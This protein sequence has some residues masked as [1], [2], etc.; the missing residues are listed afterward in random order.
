VRAILDPN[1]LI[2]A[3]LSRR[4]APAQV[5]RAWLEGRFDLIASPLLLGEL[6]RALSYPKLRQ[7]ITEAQATRL[8]ALI[9]REATVPPDPKGPPMARSRDPG[10]DYLLALVEHERAVL[11]SGDSHLLALADELPVLTPR[12]FL[13]ALKRSS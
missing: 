4:G 13:N 6:E 8:V 1:V 11:V 7:H 3:V 5:L 10:D 9:G 12:Q 2:S